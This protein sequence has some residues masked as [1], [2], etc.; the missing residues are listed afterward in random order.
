MREA[1]FTKRFFESYEELKEFLETKIWNKKVNFGTI[2]KTKEEEDIV[3]RS[4]KWSHH[5]D[6]VQ[7]M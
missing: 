6:C 3:R 7:P 4:F 1:N 5:C 2:L